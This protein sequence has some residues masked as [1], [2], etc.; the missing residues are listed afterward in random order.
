PTRRPQ[1]LRVSAWNGGWFSGELRSV[2]VPLGEQSGGEAL[3]FRNALDFDRD[4]VDRLLEMLEPGVVQLWTLAR[5][6]FEQLHAD[7]KGGD[8]DHRERADDGENLCELDDVG[9]HG[10]DPGG[11]EGGGLLPLPTRVRTDGFPGT[12]VFGSAAMRLVRSKRLHGI[13]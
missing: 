3:R 10:G 11:K 5:R 1:C 8:H 6:A 13:R 9:I 12:L 4:R 2:G 7:D